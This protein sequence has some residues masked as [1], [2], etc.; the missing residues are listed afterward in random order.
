MKT[1]VREYGCVR[2]GWR[3]ALC[4]VLA[5]LAVP[6]TVRAFRVEVKDPDGNPV[7]GFRW[8]VEEDNTNQPTPGVGTADTIALDIH[9][10]HAPVLAEGHTAGTM[11]VIDLPDDGRYFVSVLPDSGHTMSGT[12]VAAGQ[13]DVTV[14][15]NPYPMPTSQVSILAFHDN[16]AINLV[17]DLPFEEGLP[18]FS[19]VVADAAGQQMM[20]AFGNPVGTTYVMVDG[21]PVIVDGQPVVD[22]MGTGVIT[23]NELGEALVTNLP[24]G[25]FAVQLIPPA[26]EGW[27]Q[28]TTI[29]G[30]KT[31]DA[32]VDAGN[33]PLLVEFGPAFTH[34]FAGFVREFDILDEITEPEAD[35]GSITGQ[36]RFDHTSR[37]PRI[38]GFWAGP[39]V[40]RAYVGLND[41]TGRGVYFAECDEEGLFT[42]NGVPAGTYQLVTSD[43]YLDSIFGF[44]T[45][46]IPDVD[47]NWDLDL[48]DPG[49]LVFAW[50]S[51]YQGSVFYDDNENGFRDE[52]EVGIPGQDAIIRFRDGSIYQLQ[53]T[54][55]FGNWF[56]NQVFPFFKWLV[57]E[58]DF[59]RYKDT[60][61]TNIV[62]N[63]GEIPP[64]DGW[65]MPSRGVLNPQPQFEEDGVTPLINPNTGNNLSRTV[66]TLGPD[67]VKGT[68][69]DGAPGDFLL[70]AMMGFAGQTNIV[71]WGK[72]EYEPGT[73]GGITGLVVYAV[74]RA[75]DDP[76]YAAAEEWEPGVPRVQVT[77][78]QDLTGDGVIDDLDGTEQVLA[79]VD[80][81]PLGWMDD[82]E[83]PAAKG[84][85]DV[86]RNG[87]DI[88]DPGDALQIVHTDSF[89][90]NAP[91]GCLQDPVI[92]HGEQAQECFDNFG[93]WN[94]LRPGVFD[95]GFA[96][97]SY[98]PGGMA[99]TD[100][101]E[102]GPPPGFYIVE[103]ATPPGYE[104]V[105]EEDKNVDYGDQYIPP[106][107]RALPP[108]CVGDPH[109]VPA[110]LDLFGDIEAPFAGEERPLCDRKMV[111][112][113]NGQNTAATFFVF[114][115][116]PKAAR[117][118]GII[119]NDIAAEGNPTS[120][121]FGEK[122]PP[123][124]IPISFRDY[125]GNEV[126]RVYA[127]EFGSY[128][129]LLPGSYT[130]NIA[131]P[132]GVAPNMLTLVLNHPGPIPDPDNPGQFIIDPFFDPNYTQTPYTF[133]FETGKTTYLDTPVLPV[134]A[135]VGFPNR[136]LDSEPA[137]GTPVIYS[138][139]GPSGG[140][141]VCGDG[142]TITIT[143]LGSTPVANPDFNP[144]DP[145]SPILVTRD[146]GFGVASG[147]V[148]VDGVP[149]SITSWTDSTIEATADT[150]LVSTGQLIVKRGDNGLTTLPGIT[151]H[152]DAC[153]RSP[154]VHVTG[155]AVYPASPIQD[156]ID[157]AAPGTLIIVEPGT[158]NENPIIW[159][160]V[161]LQGSG[162]ASTIINGATLPAQRVLDWRDKIN[163]LIDSGDIVPLDEEGAG[164]FFAASE[165]P[166]IFIH[167]KPET[168][169][170][171]S[172]GL[173]DG[174]SVMG[175]IAGG[176][177]YV[178][179]HADYM[180]ISNCKVT[181]NQGN[182]GGGITVGT[183]SVT[184]RPCC[185]GGVPGEPSIDSFN[186]YISIHHNLIA[187]NG[188][189]NGGGGI[190][191]FAGADNYS[192]AENII[193]GNFTRFIG[194]GVLHYGLSDGGTIAGNQIV[195][196]EVFYGGQVGG[197][198]GG[199]CIAGIGINP[200][201]P[202]ALGTGSG[203]VS[204]VANLIQGNLAGSGSGGGIRALSING[205]DADGPSSEWYALNIFN[206]LVVNNVAA[207][208][209]GGIAL[210][211]AV[212]VNIIHNTIANNDASS[213]A[214]MAFSAGTLLVSEPQGAGIVSTYHS[215]PLAAATGQ[216]FA[217]PALY[218]NIIR[219]NRSFFWDGTLGDFTGDFVPRDPPYWDLQVVGD[220]NMNPEYCI[221]T[222]T[223]GYSDTNLELDPSFL[224][225]YHN[226]LFGAA[227]LE[228]GG[229][230]VTVRHTNLKIDEGNYHLADTSPAI[231]IATTDLPEA[232]AA[233][234]T[235]VDGDMRPARFGPDIGADEETPLVS[236]VPVVLKAPS[237]L[238]VA[239]GLPPESASAIDMC[240]GPEFVI[241]L[242]AQQ[243]DQTPELPPGG[244]GDASPAAAPAEPAIA[245]GGPTDSGVDETPDRGMMLAESG[246]M[247]SAD[248]EQGF[249][250]LD[251]L[252]TATGGLT[253]LFADLHY[254]A[255]TMTCDGTAAAPMF[256]TFPTGSCDEPSGT[257]DEL[258]GCSFLTGVGIA[259]EWVRVA[260]VT[261]TAD[262]RGIENVVIS[263]PADTAVSLAGLGSV[264]VA[265]IWFAETPEFELD[266]CLQDI[267]GDCGIGPGDF[268]FIPQCWLKC[269]TDPAWATFNCDTIDFD[270]TGCVDPGD[271]AFFV[272]AW[273]KDCGDPSI[274]EPPCQSPVGVSLPPASREVVESFG[275]PYPDP[276]D[277][278]F[279]SQRKEAGEPSVSR[280]ASPLGEKGDSGRIGSE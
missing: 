255:D 266:T 175:A 91:T 15:V 141:I 166:G 72:K 84:P 223:F 238:D 183:A 70:Q 253:C 116:V 10:S 2:T 23:T 143:S 112:H 118:V 165:N 8:L 244:P 18:G 274:V 178:A 45:V 7:T 115:K 190:T 243:T 78:Y 75:E 232:F 53:P 99:N 241:E 9:K 176:G 125:A 131:A 222:D 192:V 57:V 251:P 211:D 257:V 216:S 120:P 64:D 135:F 252:P 250:G 50:Y 235:D 103:A 16:M 39:P 179:G 191:L 228:E 271:F 195:F 128:N 261:M 270:C 148:T 219:L 74:T 136:V 89:D 153:A 189:N 204:V 6:D 130:T 246:P 19:V 31:I 160:N 126:V 79:D 68:E 256:S 61:F 144:D 205:V 77:L 46:T 277:H 151:L 71:D 221:L 217:D 229:N 134:A 105:K 109:T 106:G 225:E 24:P 33:P 272:T 152:V 158:Y 227:L 140:P 82:P 54:D 248:R 139:M 260:T 254:D 239:V 263:G 117:A 278:R 207:F 273:M 265:N 212:K 107:L 247:E 44:Q 119:N 185:G 35:T 154:I 172:P 188:G 65:D 194:G 62:D 180:E 97:N 201:D 208:Q 4:A 26:G 101:E 193:L 81:Y 52:G 3:W 88:F 132:S 111:T 268:S 233:L 186:D 163:A 30:T 182:F 11:A 93:T 259:P 200:A 63:G 133:N 137:D 100:V 168:F 262:E 203:S 51:V 280:E 138:V 279:R 249:E 83:N 17:P 224:M 96:I 113:S 198:G 1:T 199:I 85:E 47:G 56:L 28:T 245:F 14:I 159:K 169:D 129:A 122:Q 27:V 40:Y 34:I 209:G 226:D 264:P 187:K 121:V 80:N 58:I 240:P 220:G 123:S 174:V 196:N 206:N 210:Q 162:A 215:P 69:D 108:E 149:L 76:T 155:G 242:W 66:T 214:A 13:A 124:W 237:G 29:E 22:E 167:G 87:N 157:A 21:E 60:G 142:E 49:V 94:Q 110:F 276:D 114:S 181:N 104:I 48:T 145:G 98:F 147:E 36:V 86:D 43:Y 171:G 164:R 67:G 197:D 230:F 90:D 267:D 25:K 42:I 5:G 150:D 269:D 41:P 170:A 95:G 156:A 275:L 59:L 37:P 12:T 92:V 20:D 218:N 55:I 73:N 177:I 258:G 236:V 32:W 234:E 161:R 102:P 231:D 173:I 213:T 184:A 127:D 146:F 38:Q 202:G